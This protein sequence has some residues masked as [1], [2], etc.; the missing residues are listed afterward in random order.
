MHDG[1][2]VACRGCDGEVGGECGAQPLAPTLCEIVESNT[3][4]WL[5]VGGKGGVGKTTVSCCL[6]SL[7][8]RRRA[9]AR[10]AAAAAGAPPPSSTSSSSAHGTAS[11]A[12]P[13]KADVLLISTDPA[14]NVSD[15]FGQKFSKVPTPVNGV[16]NLHAMEIEASLE[17]LE[18]TLKLKEGDNTGGPNPFSDLFGLSEVLTSIPGIDE[19]MSFAEV[20]KQVQC[21]DYSV[22]VF[23]TAPT[24]HTLRFLSF[25]SVL[26]KGM[27]KILELK[28]KF[29]GIFSQVGT[30]FGLGGPGGF[31][32]ESLSKK[33]METKSVVDE[34]SAQFKNPALTQ[35]IPV[36]IP[37]FLSVYETERLV[38][39]LVRFE[40]D[41]TSVVVNQLV[42]P[43]PGDAC[44]LCRARN[45][46]QN[47]YVSQI[48]NLYEDFHIVLLP[49]LHNEVRGVPSITEFSQ[50]LIVPCERAHVCFPPTNP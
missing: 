43:P 42:C 25:P 22:I 49:L 13:L 39:E 20:M 1:A 14:H 46:M 9:A 2:I 33:L 48:R 36:M 12:S 44:G 11:V 8:A 37:E 32:L 7:I 17:T 50:N 40:M 6:A 28:S 47:K 5:F 35:F 23:D 16:P 30:M 18:E 34:V 27:G 29:S 38:Q 45:S 26:Q 21:M 19:A 24:G 31:D 4:K 15:A 10:G 41:V 3:L